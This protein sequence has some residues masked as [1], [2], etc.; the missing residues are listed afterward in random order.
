[1]ATFDHAGSQRARVEVHEPFVHDG[2][3]CGEVRPEAYAVRVP[4]P[5]AGGDHV[6]GHPWELVDA[7][8]LHGLPGSAGAQADLLEPVDGTRAERGPGHVGE[9]PE[10]GLEALPVW[11]DQA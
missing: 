2:R 10:H 9:K 11:P 6:V 3:A 7:G 4:D 8:D 1:D 5:D